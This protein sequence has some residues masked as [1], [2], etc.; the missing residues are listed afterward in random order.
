MSL[1]LPTASSS[2]ASSTG[3]PISL[4]G[5]S[6][7][8]Q[9]GNKSVNGSTAAVNGGESAAGGSIG[10]EDKGKAV[11]VAGDKEE[12]IPGVQGIVPTLQ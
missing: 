8:G 6:G 1:V 7:Q 2:R 10:G 9:Q 4:P 3:A 12:I 11:A 5:S